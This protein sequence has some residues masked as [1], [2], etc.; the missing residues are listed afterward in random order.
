MLD[1]AHDKKLPV[2]AVTQRFDGDLTPDAIDAALNQLEQTAR[3][4]GHAVGM[5]EA[6][7]LVIQRLTL[8]LKALPDHGIALAP[9]SSL[10]M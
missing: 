1:L 10:V 5:A 7:P 8:W 6:S 9:L 4:S 3:L 2:T